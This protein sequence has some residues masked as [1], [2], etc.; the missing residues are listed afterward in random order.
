VP[1]SYGVIA[2]SSS[3]VIQILLKDT[4]PPEFIKETGEVYISCKIAV[5][6]C[7]FVEGLDG[8]DL[9]SFWASRG[10]DALR[11]TIACTVRSGSMLFTETEPELPANKSMQNLTTAKSPVLVRTSSSADILSL[12]DIT[13][14][15]LSFV[16]GSKRSEAS[17]E[18]LNESDVYVAYRIRVSVKDMFTVPLSS[19]IVPPMQSKRLPVVLTTVPKAMEGDDSPSYTVQI[20]VELLDVP[21]EAVSETDFKALWT[22][23]SKEVSKRMI[24]AE[25]KRS[26]KASAP[27]IVVAPDE[28]ELE[29][30]I[31][32][33]TIIIFIN[34][35]I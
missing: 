24:H 34:S 26:P 16:E 14:S 20:Q 19:G 31:C 9:H 12:V 18:I 23:R 7:E 5:E 3:T 2:P 1:R 33:P 10:K 4:L 17:M 28:L 11:K 15:V 35:L 22:S 6:L 8:G 29:G 27:D 32:M 21:E 30:A 25:V 13:P